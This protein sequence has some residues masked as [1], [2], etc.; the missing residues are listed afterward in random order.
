[1]DKGV[2]LMKQG[3]RYSGSVNNVRS[4]QEARSDKEA[5]SSKVPRKELSEKEAA[6]V[7][8]ALK[9]KKKEETH[10]QKRAHQLKVS[11]ASTFMPTLWS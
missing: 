5:R 11:E 4:D 3:V 9:K 8:R 2:T 10:L 7:V 6:S 1:M